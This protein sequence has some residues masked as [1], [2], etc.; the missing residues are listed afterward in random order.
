[1]AN[2]NPSYTYNGKIA[3][4]IILASLKHSLRATA[5]VMTGVKT[6]QQWFYDNPQ[7]F[8]AFSTPESKTA[9]GVTDLE[10]TQPTNRTPS[11]VN[12]RVAAK[13]CNIELIYD[14]DG[15]YTEFAERNASG[16]SALSQYS[17]RERIVLNQLVRGMGVDAFRLSWFSDAGNTGAFY[18]TEVN[19][20]ITEMIDN[21]SGTAGSGNVFQATD[22]AST[23]TVT[24][25]VARLKE[26]YENSYIQLRALLPNEK[27][28]LVTPN[29]YYLFMEYLEGVT[30]SDGNFDFLQK[31]DG[32]LF[33]RGVEIRPVYEWEQ[34][35]GG[36]GDLE[37]DLAS[38][39]QA[40]MVYTAKSNL[41]A[42]TDNA[43]DGTSL[44][45]FWDEDTELYK[46]R[47][48]Y[49]IGA[50]IKEYGMTSFAK[51]NLV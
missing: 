30:G 14:T 49:A 44:R 45:T 46:Y 1:M 13:R 17:G 21:A 10:L 50:Y 7:N 28:F 20:L 3:Q 35:L 4:E 6:L 41:W 48:R 8:E 19:G 37:L 24:D 27:I 32:T 40:L 31:P 23:L 42:L 39:T 5:N 11:V 2:I 12:F 25:T 9:C 26:L 33:Y 36:T 18:D 15:A 29:L 51:Q 34:A 16:M 47:G 38:D 43:A 22:L